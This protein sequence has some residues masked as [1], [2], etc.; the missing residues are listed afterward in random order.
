M[1]I[2][3]NFRSYEEAAMICKEINKYSDASDLIEKSST[4]FCESG[5]PDTAVSS[6]ERIAK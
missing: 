1:H 4:L 2:L 5:S 6:L 3:V